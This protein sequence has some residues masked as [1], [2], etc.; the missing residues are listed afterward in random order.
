MMNYHLETSK[1]CMIM[2]IGVIDARKIAASV[3]F[4]IK[5][6][7]NVISKILVKEP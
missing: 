2:K 1:G 5:Q 6:I 3:V 7:A 4:S